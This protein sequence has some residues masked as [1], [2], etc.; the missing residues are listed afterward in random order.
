MRL[1]KK[2]DLMMA[3][4]LGIG[5]DIPRVFAREGAKLIVNDV[6]I[7]GGRKTVELIKKREEGPCSLR[8]TSPM[9]PEL[10]K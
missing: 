7:E 1:K 9:P 6:N 8:M 3:W 10:N 4:G 2:G 5:R